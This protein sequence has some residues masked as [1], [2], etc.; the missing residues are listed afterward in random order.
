MSATGGCLQGATCGDWRFVKLTR[1]AKQ[2][3]DWGLVRVKVGAGGAYGKI[4]GGYL[5]K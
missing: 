1:M 4:G 2:R 3:M 5:W